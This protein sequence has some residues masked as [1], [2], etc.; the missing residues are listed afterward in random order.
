MSAS[1]ECERVVVKSKAS[2]PLAGGCYQLRERVKSGRARRSDW[3]NRTFKA[4]HHFTSFRGVRNSEDVG[5]KVW[6]G[7]VK[8][9]TTIGVALRRSDPIRLQEGAEYLRLSMSEDSTGKHFWLSATSYM[10]SDLAELC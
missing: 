6:F 9:A 7:R 2:S 4:L 3:H 5:W 10:H 1:S 8:G